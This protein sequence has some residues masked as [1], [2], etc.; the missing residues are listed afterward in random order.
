[1]ST[2]QICICPDD[3]YVHRVQF[4]P[5]LVA[6]PCACGNEKCCGYALVI[7]NHWQIANHA[8]RMAPKEWYN[9]MKE[10]LYNIQLNSTYNYM[11]MYG[12][13]FLGKQELLPLINPLLP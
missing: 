10:I 2:I 12:G 1:M 13:G 3:H 7:N 9:E 4:Q 11:P 5:G 6:L 8:Y